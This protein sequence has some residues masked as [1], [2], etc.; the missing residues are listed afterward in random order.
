MSQPHG[1]PAFGRAFAALCGGRTPFLWQSRLFERLRAGDIPAHCT[2][3]TGLGKTAI[4]PIWLI[5][6]ASGAPL[7]RRLVYIVNRRTVVDQATDDAER[8]LACL[9]YS[10]QRDKLTWAVNS[11][12]GG[13]C[14][15]MSDE[16]ASDAAWLRDAL[17]RVSGDDGTAPLAVSTLRGELADNGEWMKNP[18]RPAIIIGT[19]DMIGSKLLFSGYGDGRYGRVH[20]AGLI[21][22]DSL[23]VHDESHLSPAFDELLASIER[24][25]SR[26]QEMRPARVLRLSATKRSGAGHTSEPRTEFGIT[27]EDRKDRLVVQRLDAIKRLK[28]REVERGQLIQSIVEE[29]VRVGKVPRRVLVY[30]RSPDTATKVV[31]ELKK[32][33]S[34]GSKARV[35]LLTGTLRGYERDALARGSLLTAFKSNEVAPALSQ[36]LFLVST[37]AGEVGADLDADHLVCDLTTLESMAQRFG[38]V[39]RLGGSGRSAEV[40]VVVEK[41]KENKPSPVQ[42]AIVKTGE[43]LKAIERGGGSVSPATLGKAL[44]DLSEQDRRAA[45]SPEPRILPATDVLFD[46][47]SLTSITAPM[48]GRPPV[49]PYL[50]G[51][52]EWEPPDTHVAWRADLGE[53]ARA[54]GFDDKGSELPCS[55]AELEEVLDAF[56]LR[57][58]ELLRERTDRAFE[59]L[60][61]IAEQHPTRFAAVLRDRTLQWVRLGDLAPQDK[62]EQKRALQRLGFATVILPTEVGGLAE[63]GALDGTAPPPAD[64]NNPLAHRILD[65]AEVPLRGKIERQRVLVVA[66]DGRNSAS[67][68]LGGHKM[69][70][71]S[72]HDVALSSRDGEDAAPSRWLEYR[73]AGGFDREPGTRVGLVPHN[74]AVGVLAAQFALASGLT[75]EFVA[76]I[77]Q[78]G[79]LHDTGKNRERWQRY[80][81]NSPHR[82][83]PAGPIAKSNRYGHWKEL[84]GYRHE[85][86][87][88]VDAEA[89]LPKDAAERDLILHII[90]AHHGWSR[91]HFEPR[92]FD[93]GDKARPRHTSANERT[94]VEAVQRFARLQQRLGRWTLAWFES[95]VRCADA[96]ASGQGAPNE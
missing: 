92:H 7:P 2:L 64:P 48:A 62:N 33:I 80:A 40:V 52:A 11:S 1:I 3:G 41:L 49:E 84:G 88:L 44:G 23:I 43:I 14:S 32:K 60:M 6:I 28:I 39:N 65:V 22:Q 83:D 36:S 19:I 93:P 53:L 37:S 68:F 57:S 81:R 18:A 12:I 25:Q 55:A 91:P 71:V 42:D 10:A 96:E 16:H 47:W 61:L 5:A 8:L 74:A 58:V 94:A 66:S 70:G 78:A 9:Y 90:A 15:G 50:H 29:A 51:V 59:Q 76:A 72:I 35:E 89:S 21:G 54:G 77:K 73:V 86:G 87:S 67:T 34:D 95:L 4:I 75:G 24:E 17:A 82:V 20:H 30:V 31:A 69:I 63:S 38:R 27:N 85:F 79:G 13:R 26:T 46:L 56:P 45:F